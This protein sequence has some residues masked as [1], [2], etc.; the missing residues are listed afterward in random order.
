MQLKHSKFKN[1][2]ILFEL[3]VRRVTADTLEGKESKALGLLKKYFTNTELGKEY[4]LFETLFKYSNVSETKANVVLSTSLNASKKLNRTSLRK[5]KYNLIKEIKEH[6]NLEE[7]FKIRIS[8][9]KALASF[10]I[11][12]EISNGDDNVNPNVIV[13]NKITLLDFLTKGIIS[14][15]VTK[16]KLLEEFQNYDKDTRIL[17]YHVLLEKFNSKYENFSDPQKS[18]LKEYINS[19]DSTSKLKDFYNSK[20]NEIRSRLTNLTKQVTDKVVQIKLNE[21]MKLLVEMDKN[22]KIKDNNLIDLLQY[23]ELVEELI[24]VTKP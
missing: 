9:Y 6:Y 23:S 14:K 5:E 16:D 3:L 20:I 4:K 11:L 13:E 21:V 24:K 18:I 15:N 7:F 2:G 8:H 12:L 22:Q 10:A 1:T 19:V 17:T